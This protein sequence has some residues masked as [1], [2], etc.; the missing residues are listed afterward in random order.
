MIGI[1]SSGKR[2]AETKCLRESIARRGPEAVSRHYAMDVVARKYLALYE[3]LM[4]VGCR[5]GG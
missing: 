1:T 5:T 4:G 2:Y 3:D